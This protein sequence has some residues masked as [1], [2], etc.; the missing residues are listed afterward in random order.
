MQHIIGY[1]RYELRLSAIDLHVWEGN[2][3]A[4]RLYETLG[5]ELQHRELYFRLSL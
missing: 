1:A 5:F 3:P 4:I 2:T